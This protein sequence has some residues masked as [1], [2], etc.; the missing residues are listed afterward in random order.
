[1]EISGQIVKVSGREITLSLDHDFDIN[2]AVR[3]S[4]GEMRVLGDVLDKRSIT[5]EQRRLIYA[6][7]NDAAEYTGHEPMWW[8]NLLKMM[9]GNEIGEEHVSLAANRMTQVTAGKF[10]EFIV[11][12]LLAEEIPFKF[13]EFHL[14]GDVSRILFLYLKHR[15]CF[16]CG[17]PHS[18][19]A[20]Y[21]TVGMGRDRKTIDHSL[22]RFMCLCRAHHTEQH[23][24]GM[25]TF[26]NKY[27]IAPIKL[28]PEQIAEFGIGKN[29][30][31]EGVEA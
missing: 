21:E 29:M 11:G 17:K 16:V 18:D 5:P 7:M 12:F 2:A 23:K 6:L 15:V 25:R 28:K 20:H 26:M 4:D 22:N 8:E 27:H 3:I 1:M 24:I 19:Y 13:Q 14:A 30:H 10:I 31:K 9:F